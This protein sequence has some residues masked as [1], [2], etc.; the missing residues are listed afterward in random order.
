MLLVRKGISCR[1][2]E[3]KN[4]LCKLLGSCEVTLNVGN[5]EICTL[6]LDIT[7]KVYFLPRMQRETTRTESQSI[8]LITVQPEPL[9]LSVFGVRA[10]TELLSGGGVITGW[11][12]DSPS[13]RAVPGPSWA[14]LSCS[15]VQAA[16]L[17]ATRSCDLTSVALDLICC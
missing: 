3:G 9:R 6:H 1:K 13:D 14:L 16:A 12:H 2:G 17:N 8:A 11:R 15:Q 7:V 10:R 4:Q 5:T